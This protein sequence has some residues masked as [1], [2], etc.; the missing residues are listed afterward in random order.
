ML[1]ASALAVG[2]SGA[3]GD[4]RAARALDVEIAIDSTGSMSPVIDQTKKDAAA[5]IAAVQSLDPDARFAI[6]EFRDPHYPAPEYQVLQSFTND[7]AAITAAIG[8]LNPV[9]TDYPGNVPSEAYNLVFDRSV[10]DS[11]LG[12]RSSSKKVVVV[13]GDGEPHGAGLDGLRGCVDT[14]PDTHGLNT[15]EVLGKMHA[16]GRALLMVR[17]PSPELT[18]DC[19]SSIA[20]LAGPGSAAR[21]A[22]S[23]N[24]AGT[25]GAL[26]EGTVFT[27]RTSVGYPVA[28]AG[29]KRR[30]T[31]TLANTSAISARLGRLVVQ[32]PTG[33]SFVAGSPAGVGPTVDGNTLI[34]DLS[35]VSLA[36]GRS[37]SLAA[38]ISATRIG[39]AVLRATA[40]AHFADGREVT[41][42]S[43]ASV[44][45]GRTLRLGALAG[46][47]ASVSSTVTLGYATSAASLVGTTSARGLIELG[48]GRTRI[49]ISPWKARVTEA[50]RRTAANVVGTV[51]SSRR[52]GCEKGTPV[53]IRLIDY[54]PL[55]ARPTPDV[56]RVTG[57]GCAASARVDVITR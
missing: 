49:T 20:A 13:L 33:T 37:T 44:R 35:T 12:W 3:H 4:V 57:K 1:A 8:R 21:D 19:Y 18:L 9:S 29:T 34:W 24:I 28:L 47:R 26:L 53:T 16:A 52:A 38:T 27:L 22:G 23:A 14:N 40:E 5:I 15:L 11:S 55:T 17:H 30:L 25:I 51:L 41:A 54:D 48:S 10:T 56:F 45:I 46:L 7:V 31:L 2:A 42:T 39:A 50:S 43:G 6:V 32:L 36:P